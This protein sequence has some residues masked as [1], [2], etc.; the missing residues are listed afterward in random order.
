MS[1]TRTGSDRTL[2]MVDV[3]AGS[4]SEEDEDVVR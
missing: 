1:T 4:H 2:V 3:Y